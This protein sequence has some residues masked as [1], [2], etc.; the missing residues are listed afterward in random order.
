MVMMGC[1]N[2]E[3]EALIKRRQVGKKWMRQAG[4]SR[5]KKQEVIV[6]SFFCLLLEVVNIFEVLEIIEAWVQRV[7]LKNYKQ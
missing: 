2:F 7:Q 5:M 3:D 1:I 6:E 4:S